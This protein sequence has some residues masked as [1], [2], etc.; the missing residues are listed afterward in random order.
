MPYKPYPFGAAVASLSAIAIIFPKIYN[1]GYLTI[2]NRG[3]PHLQGGK[4]KTITHF[5]TVVGG[6]KRPHMAASFAGR[7]CRQDTLP[8]KMA[9]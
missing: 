7:T 8:A 9:G 4:R 6:E 5:A 2:C 1:N 3:I